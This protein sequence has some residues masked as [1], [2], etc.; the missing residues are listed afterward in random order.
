MQEV[1]LETGR[2]VKKCA[3]IRQENKA[4]ELGQETKTAG[5]ARRRGSEELSKVAEFS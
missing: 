3:R 4:K 1:Q 5:G 2:A